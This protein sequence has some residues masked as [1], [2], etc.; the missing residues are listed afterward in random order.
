MPILRITRRHIDQEMY[1]AINARVDI[2]HRH[3]VGLIMHGALETGGTI[4]VA[5]VWESDHYAQRY[6]EDVLTPALQEVGAPLD[7][8]VTVF[9]LHHLVTP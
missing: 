6:V 3:P 5:Q 8:D 7:A 9:E 1:D 4:E 2:D